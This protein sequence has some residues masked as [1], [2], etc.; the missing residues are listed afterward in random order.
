MDGSVLVSCPHLHVQCR[1]NSH[2]PLPSPTSLATGSDGN[3][4]DLD[5]FIVCQ[6]ERDYEGLLRKKYYYGADEVRE[7][8]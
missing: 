3:C 4:S 2:P 5:D 1:L 7:E 6:P 8:E